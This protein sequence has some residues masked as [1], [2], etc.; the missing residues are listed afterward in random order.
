MFRNV[1]AIVTEGEFE[2][3]QNSTFTFPGKHWMHVIVLVCA[4][5]YV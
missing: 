5:S 4:V 1:V 2:L 3:I